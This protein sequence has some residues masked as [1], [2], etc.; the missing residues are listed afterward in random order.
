MEINNNNNEQDL[1][2]NQNSDLDSNSDSEYI[3]LSSLANSDCKNIY[4][5]HLDN[6]KLVLKLIGKSS[7]A[8]DMII[9]ENFGPKLNLSLLGCVFTWGEL[10]SVEK[11]STELFFPLIK[12]I[13]RVS[14]D[15]IIITSIAVKLNEL[16]TQDKEIELWDIYWVQT[17]N[18][19]DTVV[20]S[21]L[22][23]N[24]NSDN[25]LEK[26]IGFSLF[27]ENIHKNQ[28]EQNIDLDQNDQI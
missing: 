24:I 22:E 13:N 26:I 23:K 6:T 7:Y 2:Y 11:K 9:K 4:Q 16:I 20:T 15:H 8:P 21:Q 1:I 12:L 5:F 27:N 18:Q 17:D 14:E 25:I 10:E 19:T 28:F 3:D